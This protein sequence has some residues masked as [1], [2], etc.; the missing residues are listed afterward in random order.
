MHVHVQAQNL[1]VDLY[2]AQKDMA[3][4]NKK[5]HCGELGWGHWNMP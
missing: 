3:Q 1:V 5:G 2:L 4:N